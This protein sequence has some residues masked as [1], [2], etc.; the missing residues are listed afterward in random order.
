MFSGKHEIS[1]TIAWISPVNAVCPKPDPRDDDFR[2]F[3]QIKM[4]RVFYFVG[5]NFSPTGQA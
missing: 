5:N 3:H 2:F 1:T 4:L